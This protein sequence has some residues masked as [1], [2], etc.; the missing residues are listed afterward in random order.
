MLK[1][2]NPNHRPWYYSYHWY[3][4]IWYEF[5]MILKE[6]EGKLIILE[7]DT[8]CGQISKKFRDEED[9]KLKN[10]LG[11]EQFQKF[12]EYMKRMQE[13][14]IFAWDE[15]SKMR[16]LARNSHYLE[17]EDQRQKELDRWKEYLANR[18]L[19]EVQQDLEKMKKSHREY[20]NSLMREVLF[21]G[22]PL[23]IFSRSIRYTTNYSLKII[24]DYF[25]ESPY[26]KRSLQ[27]L[28]ESIAER[29]RIEEA[30]LERAQLVNNISLDNGSL[31]ALNN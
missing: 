20:I 6:N 30:L 29:C 8:P 14:H 13:D 25:F 11:E 18:T 5:R 4:F 12:E 16:S 21:Y 7:D 27:R 24:R 19:E 23:Y 17:E 28:E 1:K 2:I 22:I 9:R 10:F 3:F 15:D 26:Q 31:Y